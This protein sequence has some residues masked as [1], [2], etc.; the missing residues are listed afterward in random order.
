MLSV[1]EIFIY[2]IKSLGG[3][4]VTSAM[5]TPRGLQFDRRWML[6]DAD[7]VF[8]TQREHPQLALY[9]VFI[10]DDGLLVQH[11]ST[12][13][14]IRIPFYPQADE[15]LIVRVWQDLC[16]ARVVSPEADTWFSQQLGF[17][18]RLVYMPDE[19]RRAVD[20]EYAFH[21]EITGFSDAFPFLLIGQAS[22]NDLNRRLEEPLPINRFRPNIVFTGGDAFEEDRL[23]EFTIGQVRFFGVKPCS[24]CAI[25]TTNQETAVRGKEPL[26]T[27]AGYRMW[28]NKI[29]FGQNLLH[30]GEGWIKVGDEME[31]VR[32]REVRGEW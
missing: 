21:D 16:S 31:V 7:Q 9:R 28:N 22:L 29:Y 20:R 14:S 26:K 2:P 13:E 25:T 19:A 4:S 12:G 24:R 6:V 15:L 18:C 32:K 8:I 5:V 11:K 10:H 3:I 27:L 1:S 23:E 30:K 17:P